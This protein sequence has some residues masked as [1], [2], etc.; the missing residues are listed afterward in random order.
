M[1]ITTIPAAMSKRLFMKG[2]FSLPQGFMTGRR[3]DHERVS[4]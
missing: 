1:V 3:R 4:P 2:S